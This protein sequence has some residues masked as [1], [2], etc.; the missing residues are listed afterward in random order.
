M[1]CFVASAPRN[2]GN[3]S[4][5]QSG[6]TYSFAMIASA[7]KPLSTKPCSCTRRSGCRHFSHRVYRR[8]RYRRNCRHLLDR[9]VGVFGDDLQERLCLVVDRCLAVLHRR[10]NHIVV[11]AVGARQ[12]TQSLVTSAPFATVL[13]EANTRPTAWRLVADPAKNLRRPSPSA[14]A[15][16]KPAAARID[17]LALQRAAAFDSDC[18]GKHFDVGKPKTVF[19]GKQAS[20]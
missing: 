14:C 20:E 13:G 7:E 15:Q 9:E 12:R 4:T 2:D 5:H 19:V 18:S 17:G 16:L 1:D 3:V 10:Q 11:L 6:F 8:D